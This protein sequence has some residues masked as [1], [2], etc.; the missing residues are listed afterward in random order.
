M[1]LIIRSI[2]IVSSRHDDDDDDEIVLLVDKKYK[3]E[4]MKK[5]VP[6]G[7]SLLRG[8]PNAKESFAELNETQ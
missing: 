4:K 7:D 8:A 5:A 2:T 1:L 6:I 3:S